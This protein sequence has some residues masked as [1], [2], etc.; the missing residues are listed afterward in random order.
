MPHPP[1]PAAARPVPVDTTDASH[2]ARVFSPPR[3]LDRTPPAPVGPAASPLLAFDSVPAPPSTRP[4]PDRPASDR[5]PPVTRPAD[6]AVGCP[7]LPEN[8]TSR[9]RPS[10]QC[11]DRRSYTPAIRQP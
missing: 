6:A 5:N 1:Q 11:P 4:D 2:I 9:R 8:E 3:A 10:H 7:T